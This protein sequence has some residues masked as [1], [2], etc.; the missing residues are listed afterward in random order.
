MANPLDE[1]KGTSCFHK[2]LFL[3][4]WGALVDLHIRKVSGNSLFHHYDT[5]RLSN[6]KTI[7]TQNSL[8]INCKY[9]TRVEDLLLFRRTELA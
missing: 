1:E 9:I 3:H 7:K 6:R 2:A 5:T 4:R 8:F